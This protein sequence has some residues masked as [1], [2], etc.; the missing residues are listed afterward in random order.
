LAICDADET[1]AVPLAVI[2]GQKELLKK[3]S[4][5][6][7][8]ENVEAIVVGLPLN[9]DNSKG[10]QAKRV[11]RFTEQ[12]KI[13]INIPVHFQDERLSSFAAEEKLAPIYSTRAKKKKRIDAFAA[14]VILEA[15]LE[16]NKE[17]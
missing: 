10:H 15:F 12:L 17:K 9:M 5:F 7:K 8:K 11:L 14:A 3:I 4:E 2:Y 1:I 13:H 6:V 16:K